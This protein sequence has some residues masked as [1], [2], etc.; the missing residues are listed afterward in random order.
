[1]VLKAS[2]GEGHLYPSVTGRQVTAGGL[3]PGLFVGTVL[4]APNSQAED[5]TLKH[6]GNRELWKVLEQENEYSKKKSLALL[7]N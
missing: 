5:F 4:E 1:M 7:N 2:R 6:Q 3:E